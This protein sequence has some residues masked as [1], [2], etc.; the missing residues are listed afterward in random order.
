MTKL[1][2]DGLAKLLRSIRANDGYSMTLSAIAEIGKF[3]K[4]E[5]LDPSFS[6]KEFYDEVF[7]MKVFE[8]QFE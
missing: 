5:C 1:Q 7:Q 8:C 2:T 6:E 3:A 4:E